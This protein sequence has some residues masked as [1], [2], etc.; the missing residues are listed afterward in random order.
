MHYL[1]LDHQKINSLGKTGMIKKLFSNV[2]ELSLTNN[3]IY[4]LEI[5]NRINEEFPLLEKL[6]LSL[7]KF[8][9]NL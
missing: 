5:L 3:L 8:A 7:N 6:I 2:K 9:F 4:D 1:A